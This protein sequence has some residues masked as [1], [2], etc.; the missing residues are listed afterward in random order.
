MIAAEGSLTRLTRNPEITL[1]W[2]F[3]GSQAPQTSGSVFWEP[4]PQAGGG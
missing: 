2:W 4:A 1:G 3:F